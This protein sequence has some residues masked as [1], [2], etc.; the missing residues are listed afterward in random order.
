MRL[1]TIDQTAA[2]L[3]KCDPDTQLTKT[4]LRR[5]VSTGQLPSV[6]VG[7]KYLLDLDRLEADLFPEAERLEAEENSKY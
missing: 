3:R 4:A 6:Q 2:W 1:R 7:T 5:M